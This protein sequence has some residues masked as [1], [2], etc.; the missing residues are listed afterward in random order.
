MAATG[1]G[2]V[3]AAMPKTIDG[4]DLDRAGVLELLWEFN[5]DAK[6]LSRRGLCGTATV[7]YADCHAAIDDC[8]EALGL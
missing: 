7:E 4:T 2:L 3:E 8:L 6:A 5:A 1:T